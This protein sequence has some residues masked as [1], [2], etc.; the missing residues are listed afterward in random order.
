MIKKLDNKKLLGVLAVFVLIF[1]ITDYLRDSKKE[2][3]S[4]PDYIVE[5]NGDTTVSAFTM[6]PEPG[7]NEIYFS[8]NGTQWYVESNGIKSEAETQLIESLLKQILDAKP[9]RLIARKRAQWEKYLLTDSLASKISFETKN[10][11]VDLYV[12]KFSYSQEPGAGQGGQPNFKVVTY[13]RLH[14]GETVYALDEG[15]WASGVKRGF[16]IWRRADFSRLAKESVTNI[17]FTYADQRFELNKQDSI[18]MMG[19]L[20]VDESVVDNYLSSMINRQERDFADQFTDANSPAD[21]EIEVS[22]LNMT[23]LIIKCWEGEGE[24]YYFNSSMNPNAYFK[25][26]STGLFKDLFVAKAYFSEGG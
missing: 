3:L 6:Y 16:N 1:F 9:S 13:V 25:G 8:K 2:K 12:G 17:K 14:E 20:L 4:L 18:W 11:N 19:D 26:D 24:K 7:L 22:G 15:F 23:N 10:G 21:Y 5:L